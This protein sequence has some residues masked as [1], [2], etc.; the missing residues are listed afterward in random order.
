MACEKFG[1]FNFTINGRA[2]SPRGSWSI[3]PTNREIEAESNHDGTMYI[4]SKPVPAS[5]EGSLSGFNDID[6]IMGICDQ[7]VVFTF[8]DGDTYVFA[9]A[10]IVGRP[11]L[12]TENGELSGIKIASPRAFKQ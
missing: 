12:N 3:M 6:L 10:A 1:T 2:Y 8:D 11:S 4:T 9:G 5:A 7:D